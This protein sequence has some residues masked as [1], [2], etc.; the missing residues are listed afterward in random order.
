M[1]KWIVSALLLI[2][3]SGFCQTKND[4]RLTDPLVAGWKGENVCEVLEE[5]ERVRALKCTFAPGVGH[6]RHFHAAHFGYTLEGGK[7]QITDT[8]GTREVNVPTG[9]DFYNEHIEW[10]QVLNVGETTAV[11][12]IVEPK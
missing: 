3:G 1:N 8:T 10:H 11:F 6:D 9:Y 5:N 12:L 2:S 7:F 4:N